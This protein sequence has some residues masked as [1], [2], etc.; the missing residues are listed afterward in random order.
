M[1]RLQRP[2]SVARTD[3]GLARSANEDNFVDRPKAG[4]WGVADGMG[5]HSYGERASR[6]ICEALETVTPSAD[7]ETYLAAVRTSLHA[8]HD[9]IRNDASI[10]V[11]GSTV[12][13]LVVLGDRY[14]CIWAGDSR[15]YR[16]RGSQLER[17]TRDHSLVEDLVAAGMLAPEAAFRHPLSNRI[18]RAVGVGDDLEFDTARGRIVPGDRFLLSSDGLHGVVPEQEIAGLAAIEDLDAAADAMIKA[19]MQAGAPDNVT[20]VL[21]EFGPRE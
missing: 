20:L 2:R 9:Q 12:A 13:A 18:T 21:V 19:V 3:I 10:G 14:A 17:L 11:C 16:L 15:V 8:V 4:L 5:G 7:P 1:T 6:L